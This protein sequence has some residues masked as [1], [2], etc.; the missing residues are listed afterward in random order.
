MKRPRIVGFETTHA[1]R[2]TAVGGREIHQ[3]GLRAIERDHAIDD[4]R[5]LLPVRSDV[6]NRRAAHSA[7]DSRETF[8]AAQRLRDDRFDQLVPRFAGARVHD[9]AAGPFCHRHAGHGHRQHETVEAFIRDD[10][11]TSAP[12][13]E[14]RDLVLR[15]PLMNGADV[16]V[17]VGPGKPARRAADAQR[18]ERLERH[19]LAQN[20]GAAM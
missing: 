6:L 10:K 4:S 19:V 16:V 17:G 9:R 3:L 12:Q 1:I 13:H 11:I 8:H 15:A 5:H 2:E 7:R 20:E 18:A 14:K